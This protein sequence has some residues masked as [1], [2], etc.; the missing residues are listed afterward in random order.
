MITIGNELFR[1]PESLFQLSFLGM[2][3]SGIYEA[4]HNSIMKC[5]INI[6]K[7]L[8]ANTI[9]SEGSTLFPGIADR[10]QKKIMALAP[11]TMKISIIATPEPK[12]SA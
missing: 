11:P 2:E 12:Y 7:D 8:Y 3:P 1:C 5:N 6:R 4:T 9:L 10:M